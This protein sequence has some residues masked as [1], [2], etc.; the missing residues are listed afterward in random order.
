MYH[1]ANGESLDDMLNIWQKLILSV[2]DIHVPIKVRRVRHKSSPW[3]SS[4]IKSLIIKN[5][6]KKQA[7][8]SGDQQDWDAFKKFRNQINNAIRQAKSNYYHSNSGKYW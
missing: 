2:A 5:N 7:I 4:G 8:K 6:F 1:A 3:L